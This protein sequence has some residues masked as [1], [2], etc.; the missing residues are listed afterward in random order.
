MIHALGNRIC[1]VSAVL[2]GSAFLLGAPILQA[3]PGLGF[4]A[5]LRHWVVDLDGD[6]SIDT[7][8]I[9][10]TKIDAENTLDMDTSKT[11]LDAEVWFRLFSNRFNFSWVNLK[12][13]G[14]RNLTQSVVFDGTTYTAGTTVDSRLE[15]EVLDGTFERPIPFVGEWGDFS[16][17]MLLGAKL[18]NFEGEIESAVLSTTEEVQAPVPQVGLSLRGKI[19]PVEFYA[20][21]KGVAI[22][23]SDVSGHMLDARGEIGV[24]RLYGFAVKGGYRYLGFAIESD[25]AELDLVYSGPY[26]TLSYE[27]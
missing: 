12:N 10:G 11:A 8:T 14:N 3:A 19:S 13:T 24:G 20:G 7:S 2:A 16:V 15:L 27:F 17:N 9:V 26:A 25:D 18:I 21:V 4:G 23:L 22:D 5:E 1:A 6:I